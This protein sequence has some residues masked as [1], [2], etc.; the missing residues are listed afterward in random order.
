MK[1]ANE[2][3]TSSAGWIPALCSS[4]GRY[5]PVFT[6]FDVLESA[7]RLRENVSMNQT[8]LEHARV[9]VR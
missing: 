4:P 3:H 9:Q 2:S 8:C 7:S 6:L 5:L 1:A